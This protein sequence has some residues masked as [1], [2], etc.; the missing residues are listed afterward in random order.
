M[1]WLLNLKRLASVQTVRP[2][3]EA[4]EGRNRGRVQRSGT[5]EPCP[6]DH[7]TGHGSVRAIDH[8]ESETS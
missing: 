6:S 1:G 8:R 5:R 2:N 3:G 4:S 7:H